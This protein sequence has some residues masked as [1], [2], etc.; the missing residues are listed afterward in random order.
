[1]FSLVS[2]NILNTLQ[3]EV[4]LGYNRNEQYKEIG[5]DGTYGA[6]FP[7][8]DAG[9]DYIFDR[10]T[11]VRFDRNNQVTVGKLF[12]NEMDSYGGFSVPL[13][14]VRGKSSTNLQ[15]GTDIV[16][17]RQYFTGEFKDLVQ[18]DGFTYL[19]SFVSLTHRIQ[20]AQ[21]QIYPRLAQSLYLGYDRAANSTGANQFLASGYLYLPG[22]AFT[23]SLVLG[24]A[25]QGR[26]SLN[27]GG[28]SNGFPFSRGYTAENFYRM[29]RLAGNYYFPLAYPDWGLGNALYF[30]R[31]R[32]NLFYDY[33]T[34]QDF[35]PTD[36][37]Y[38]AF[39]RPFG[40]EIYCD[41]QW[42]NQL[43]ISF[44]IRYSRLLDPDPEGGD[45]TNGS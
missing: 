27:Q 45:P 25:F 38:N 9:W 26:D 4:Y 20:Q 37:L 32:A 18:D 24:A 43:A 23:H 16:Y 19:R 22:L 8:I 28:F 44:G 34:V 30:L 15:F 5:L 17:E 31:I 35:D 12:W 6:L 10:N 7:W 42:W 41:T 21:Q 14:L 3:S 11:L 29:Y 33:T 36:K 40:T 13:Y 2:E 39:Y 1:M